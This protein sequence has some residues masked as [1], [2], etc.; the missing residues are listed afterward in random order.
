MTGWTREP[1]VRD[2]G[3][4]RA[5]RDAPADPAAVR[6]ARPRLAD[7]HRRQVAPVLDARRRA[8]PRDRAASSEGV[9]LEGIRRVL[10]LENEVADLRA[11]VRE[12]EARS[13]TRCSTAPAAR[14]FAAGTRATSC[15]SRRA[16]ACA[17]RTR[18]SCGARSTRPGAPSPSAGPPRRLKAPPSARVR[19]A[20][21]P[22][23][24]SD[25]LV[26]S[27]AP[28]G[29]VAVVA[30]GP[31]RRPDGL[32]GRIRGVAPASAASMAG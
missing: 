8:A 14:V 32:R 9:S 10:G 19:P 27:G 16:R 2:L 29:A 15:R 31:R 6:P 28:V 17:A 4:G 11:R 18:S 1:A 7:A 5:R 26:G 24:H 12:L 20:R 25:H 23:S 3:R 21:A 30:R 22:A 13:P